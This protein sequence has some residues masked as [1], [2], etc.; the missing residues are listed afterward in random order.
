MTLFYYDPKR[1]YVMGRAYFN[2]EETTTVLKMISFLHD[3]K[4]LDGRHK[5]MTLADGVRVVPGQGLQFT[6]KETVSA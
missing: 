2:E 1:Q 3:T 5:E 6:Y 4:V